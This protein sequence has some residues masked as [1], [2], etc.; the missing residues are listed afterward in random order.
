MNRYSPN[1]QNPTVTPLPRATRTKVSHVTD[2]QRNPYG[3]VKYTVTDKHGNVLSE[4]SQNVD[5]LTTMYWLHVYNVFVSAGFTGSYTGVT[6]GS[7][8]QQNRSFFSDG[9]LETTYPIMAGT[10]NA[11]V[12]YSQT[13]LVA[14]TGEGVGTGQLSAEPS[15]VRYRD[16]VDEVEIVRTFVNADTNASTL[17]IREVGIV[18]RTPAGGIGV[19][20]CR[21]IVEPGID[22]PFE[23]VLTVV[24]TLTTFN[25]NKNYKLLMLAPFWRDV[26]A[27]AFLLRQ[28]NTTGV[29]FATT[30]NGIYTATAL[31]GDLNGGIL[32][33]S[34]NTVATNNNTFDMESLITNGSGNGQLVYYESTYSSFEQD[35]ATNSCRFYLN[36]VVK[37]EGATPVVVNEIGLASNITFTGNTAQRFLWDRLFPD[38][39]ADTIAPGAF[40]TY[41]WEICYNMY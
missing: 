25:G 12:L 23:G 24:Y 26:N 41:S 14:P 13:A 9:T 30:T 29:E 40:A 20:F 2:T 19:L 38:N 15:T 21:D 10:S 37:N 28:Y 5:S 3:T 34:G 17:T 1:N 8:S 7:T 39:G 31:F 6:G 33:G 36:R 35:N 11:A 18:S 4:N 32:L 27:K 22:V 16:D